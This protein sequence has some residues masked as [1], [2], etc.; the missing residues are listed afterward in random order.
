MTQGHAHESDESELPGLKDGEQP[1]AVPARSKMPGVEIVPLRRFCDERG[2]V[3]HMLKETDPH[4]KRFGEIYFSTVRPGVVKAWKNHRTVTA[5]YACIFGSVRLVLYDDRAPSTTRGRVMELVLGEDY[6]AL[7]VVP[8]GVW[9]GF[10][11]LSRPYAILASCS[12]EPYNPSEFERVDPAT[13][14]IPYRWQVDELASP[15]K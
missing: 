3:Y 10:Q 14:R 6:Y 8:P 1:G 7:V 13:E 5:N 11:G 15:P 2:G 4:F 9:N 12:T